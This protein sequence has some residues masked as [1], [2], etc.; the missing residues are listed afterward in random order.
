[1]KVSTVLKRSLSLVLTVVMLF[2]C[3]VFTA[4]SASAATAG[5]YW[6]KVVFDDSKNS[7]SVGSSE[8]TLYYK[9]NNGT[10]QES[11]MVIDNSSAGGMFGDWKGFTWEQ[12]IDGYPSGVSG[13]VNIWYWT[14]KIEF[15][16]TISVWD[17]NTSTYKEVFNSG[18][19]TLQNSGQ[20]NYGR[21]NVTNGTPYANKI[22][23][24]GGS[25][26][27]MN[28]PTDNKESTATTAFTLGTVKDQYGVNWYDDPSLSVVDWDGNAFSDAYI[29]NQKLVVKPSANRSNH[30]SIRIKETCGSV[31]NTN[32]TVE[33]KVFDYKVTFY[34]ENG[35]TVLK[36]EQT[37]DYG[38]T[39]TAPSSPTKASTATQHFTFDKWTG[40]SYQNIT[41]GAETKTVKASYTAAKHNFGAPSIEFATNGQS[42][43]A[44]RTC[45][46]CGYVDKKK[47]TVTSKVKTAATCSAVG[48]TT[49]TATATFTKVNEETALTVTD[50]KDVDDIS[51]VDTA[52]N[53]TNT[54]TYSR[55]PAKCGEDATYWKECS[56]N[57]NHKAKTLDTTQ[58]WTDKDTALAHN[59]GDPTKLAEDETYR[60]TN[61]AAASYHKQ[62][63]G[64]GT[65]C[66]DGADCN[67]EYPVKYTEHTMSPWAYTLPTDD[68]S[69][70]IGIVLEQ[71]ADFDGESKCYSY[72]IYCGYTKTQS[73]HDW[74]VVEDE[75][76]T[77]DATCTTAGQTTSACLDCGKTKIETIP[78]LGHDPELKRQSTP[79]DRTAGKCYYQC[80]RCDK[81][82]AAFDNGTDYYPDDTAKDTLQEA[83]AV[84]GSADIPAP[85][86]NSYDDPDIG[87]NYDLRGASLKLTKETEAGVNTIQKMRFAG[88]VAV[89]ANMDNEIK[90]ANYDHYIKGELDQITDDNCILDFGFVYTQ[91]QYIA[92][93]PA[94]DYDSYEPDLSKI[95][96]GAKDNNGKQI[97]FQMSVPSK[98][99]DSGTLDISGDTS[100][101]AGVSP[102]QD[103]GSTFLTFNLLINVK[104]KNW[105]RI[106]AART[107]ITYKYHGEIYTVYDGTTDDY[108]SAR[109][110]WYVAK[111]TLEEYGKETEPSIV[112]MCQFLRENITEKD[113][114]EPLIQSDGNGSDWWRYR[115]DGL[116]PSE[117]D[118]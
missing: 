32:K 82:F 56:H 73:H 46:N 75:T 74:Q 38:G 28:V 69:R 12:Q 10:G 29:S 16:L 107:Y 83:L 88:S 55:T 72:C 112:K 90:Y 63:C 39:A 3:W 6:V 17:Y 59:Y 18:N 79:D 85:T 93:E 43:D 61:Y 115:N 23:D 62:I 78:A 49:Y 2:S 11:S 36:A 76:V 116:D 30:Y 109:A 117:Y 98:N 94:G 100:T 65:L 114:I 45:S 77:Y 15:T 57:T 84:E 52:H 41:N 4:P 95:V 104:E 31:S 8:C 7:A 68:G 92:E 19:T 47:A 97:V 113:N 102:H 111:A 44:K 64:R 54:K 66:N 58:Y 1:M 99:S 96:I 34:D 35:T 118:F 13:W 53:W 5:K 22:T 9:S 60:E 26:S 48:T 21:W 110:V 86:F 42:A 70:V 51:I 106:Y 103:S 20:K 14:G 25:L 81:Y 91:M 67:G 50:T 87:Y 89:P 108:G 71:L 24:V 80:T 40:D 27:S 37:I 101:W 33:L 105:K